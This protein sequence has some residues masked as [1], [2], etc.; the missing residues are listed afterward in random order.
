MR[1]VVVALHCLVLAYL[2]QSHP[3][4]ASVHIDPI[5][6]EAF[7]DGAVHQAMH[8]QHIAGMAVAVVDANGP[9]LV[10]GYGDAGHGHAVDGDTLFRVGSIS[11]TITWIAI[12]QLVEQ[13]KLRLSDPINTHLPKDLQIPDEGF[14]QPIRVWNL[15]TH[16]AGFEDSDL[17]LPI[18]LDL[19]RAMT[20]SEFLKRY[21]VHRVR[22]PGQIIVYSNYGASLAGAIIEH[23]T[24][25]S[26]V[27]YVEKNLL[28][29]LGLQT[30][31]F[32][33]PYPTS[34]A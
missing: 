9:L 5:R 20:T 28:R 21:R 18:A 34:F 27:D 19:T 17:G 26:Y 24:G 13:G 3:A 25:I 14:S 4:V 16:T 15:M 11:K 22:P 30:A 10:K 1:N 23:E 8:D 6:L 12:M 7:V 31:S 2:A 29:P 32:R 33:E